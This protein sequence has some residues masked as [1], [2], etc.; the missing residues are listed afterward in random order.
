MFRR[1]SLL[2]KT[3]LFLTSCTFFHDFCSLNIYESMNK[4]F[5]RPDRLG[6]LERDFTHHVSR[7]LSFVPSFDMSWIIYVSCV[8]LFL[9]C[10]TEQGNYTAVSQDGQYVYGVWK[11]RTAKAAKRL[12]RQVAQG[13]AEELPQIDTPSIITSTR[14][15]ELLPAEGE[16]SHWVRVGKPSVDIGDN[17]YKNVIGGNP[18]LYHSYGFVE[19][20]TIE[21]QTPRLGSQPLILLEVFDMGTPENAFGVYSRNRY[22]QDE[23]EWVGSRAIISGR[24]LN[25]WKGRYFIKIEGYEFASQ[26]KQG[27]VELA[28]ATA[29]G[30]KDPLTTPYLLT[31]LPSD[32]RVP[33]SEKYF[34]SGATLKG[35]HRFLPER[36]LEF[37]PN[38]TGCSAAYLHKKSSTDWI[39]TVTVFVLRYETE[40]EAKTAHDIYREHLEANASG[41]D[42]TP[43]GGIVVKEQ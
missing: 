41:V 24:E 7:A 16:A 32:N 26:I 8:L 25:F 5:A 14:P 13:W 30:I 27:M 23:F 31:L 35:I 1:R 12:S 22:P 21:Y 6:S 36:L 10:Q 37:S 39:D 2:P 40:S 17:L 15:V 34:P 11:A 4:W 18:E 20:A 29:D 28:K 3:W 38:I 42:S 19:G 43:A 33:H 9:S